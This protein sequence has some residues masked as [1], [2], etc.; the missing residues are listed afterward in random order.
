VGGFGSGRPRKPLAAHVRNGTLRPE[1]HLSSGLAQQVIVD[2]RTMYG[3]L[4]RLG[5]RYMAAAEKGGKG[6]A[7]ATGAA[8]RCWRTALQIAARLGADAAPP[9]PPPDRLAAHLARRTRVVPLRGREQYE[10]HDKEE[11]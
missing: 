6:A 4:M 11:D 9:T 7:R 5:N 2:G 8:I 10:H 1:R 3:R